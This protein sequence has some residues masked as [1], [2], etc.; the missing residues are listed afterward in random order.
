MGKFVGID[1]RSNAVRVAVVRTG[2]RTLALEALVEIDLA[3]VSTLEQAIRAVALPVM[4]HVDGVATA[5]GG[6]H[7]F[8]HRLELPLTTGKR[9]AEVLPFE[10]EAQVPVDIEDLVLDYLVLPRD[11][12]RPVIP[13]MTASARTDT[14]RR[15]IELLRGA[16]GRDPERVAC[17]GLALSNLV[18]LIPAL[19][20]DGPLA[21][22]DLGDKK[23]D[24]LVL[25]RG[26]AHFARTL[27]VGVEG[28]PES[29]PRLAALMR[30][31]FAAA[32]VRTGEPVKALYLC[33]TG[34][35]APGAEAYLRAELD[36]DVQVL[37]P[38]Q[39]DGLDSEQIAMLPRF[40][41]ALGL[42]LGLR[43]RPLDPDLRRGGLEFQRGF[44]FLQEKAPLLGGLAATVLI[45]FFFSAWAE[46]RALGQ[47]NEVLAS[48]LGMLTERALGTSTEDAEEAS[49]LLDNL[50]SAD[51]DPMPRLDAFDIMVEL[52]KAVPEEIVHDVDEFEFQ[53]EHMSIR[54]IVSTTAEAQTIVDNLKKNTC[55]KDIK[56]AKVTQVVNS[57]RQKYVMEFDV[58][59]PEEAETKKPRGGDR[60]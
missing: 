50:A 17:G 29:A 13:V 48:S 32:G 8:V 2:Y 45:S 53:R 18:P 42:A 7:A 54:G 37:P 30:Q 1:I 22:C 21:V 52:S 10:L 57:T 38:L 9:L 11:P 28:L 58:I 19:G 39:I 16:I 40:A 23:T 5:I 34:A 46:L 44:A 26:R 51:R 6:E 24:V 20:V 27:S 49:E 59:C 43:S 14:V 47:E 60:D 3:E 56:I 4:G 55:L 41:R 15:Q 36:V 25:G 31:T 33:G 35:F 12:D